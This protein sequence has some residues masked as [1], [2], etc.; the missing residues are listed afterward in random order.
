MKKLTTALLGSLMLSSS[1]YSFDYKFSGNVQDFSKFGFNNDK[2]NLTEGKYPTDSYSVMTA[3]LGINLDAGYG[4]S[5]GLGGT[6]GGVVFDSTKYQG[7]SNPAQGLYAPNGLMYN[8]FGFWAGYDYRSPAN[9][10]TAKYYIIQNA[11]INYQYK[12]WINLTGGRF[13]L[14]GDIGTDWMSGYIQGVGLSSKIIPYTKLWFFT[15]NRRASYGQYWLKDFKYLNPNISADN[16]QGFYVYAA[17]ANF[18]YKGFNIHPYIYAQ[19]SRFIAPGVHLGYDSNPDFKSDGFRS[20]TEILGLFMTHLSS[21]LRKTTGNNNYPAGYA[22]SRDNY[23]N[24][25]I[26]PDGSYIGKGGVSLMIRQTFYIDNYTVGA[27]LYKNFGNPNEFLTGYGDPTGFDNYDNS[28]YDSAAWN[29]VFR[30]EAISGYIFATGTYSKLSWGFLTRLTHSP[31]ADE[32]AVS[33]NVDYKFPHNI[34]AGIK[35]EYY[36]NTTFKGYVLGVS[37]YGTTTLSKTL[38]QDRSFTQTYISY[39]F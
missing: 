9:S 4:F 29:N 14:S 26:N 18:E 19:D 17:G 11:F 37:T 15:T 31:R 6:V 21:A 23:F 39:D 3:A 24:I 7:F 13:R 2:I 12:N 32:Q 38:S 1:L 10:H 25:R 22:G 36:N 5:F 34:K 8:Y 20:K 30:R 28:V 27:I 16:G 35:V 33:V